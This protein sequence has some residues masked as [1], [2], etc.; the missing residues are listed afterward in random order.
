MEI[1]RTNVIEI[2]NS[3]GVKPDKDYGQNYLI[4][5]QICSKI[6]QNFTFFDN[7]SVLEVGPGIGSLTH[8][9][10][11]ESVN[12]VG[13]DVDERMITFL[14]YHYNSKNMQFVLDDIRKHDVKRYDYICGNL[15]YN[16][17]TDLIVYLLL[18]SI[19]CKKFVFMC[20]SETL[21]H[22]I[23]ISGKEYGPTSVL[24]HLL[25][26]IKR[27]FNVKPGS[28]Y[29]SPK[30]TSSVFEIISRSNSNR[31]DIANTYIFAK[32]MFQNRRKTILNNLLNEIK[33]KDEALKALS[34]AKILPET[35]PESISPE[36]YLRL[37]KI[38]E[39]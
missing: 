13:V 32:K 3:F 33:D 39:K 20:Q 31:K 17:T 16:I 25:G 38:I 26:S 14:E 5:P 22:F 34:E 36:Q 37:Y 24:I 30:C 28:F 8:F 4:D 18:N 11:K 10:E 9:F 12:Y 21:N 7:C 2:V 15:P 1:N 19:N 23:D 27:L 35:R 6:V 29:P